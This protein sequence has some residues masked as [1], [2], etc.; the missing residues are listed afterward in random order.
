MGIPVI[1]PPT[2][3]DENDTYQREARRAIKQL[4][5]AG[6]RKSTITALVTTSNTT[7]PHQLGRVPVGWQ[8][9]DLDANAVVWRVAASTN[10]HIFLRASANAN[11]TLQLW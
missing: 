7:V 6:L 1:R 8:V 2:I 10:D 3:R 5:T 4:D 9:I 11:V